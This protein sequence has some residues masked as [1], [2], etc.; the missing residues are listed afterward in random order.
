MTRFL[1]LLFIGLTVSG[2]AIGGGKIFHALFWIRAAV[3][4]N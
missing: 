3:I 2:L 1:A 4:L